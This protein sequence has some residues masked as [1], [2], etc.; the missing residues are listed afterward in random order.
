MQESNSLDYT[1]TVKDLSVLSS[2]QKQEFHAIKSPGSSP[3]RSVS[4]ANDE[5]EHCKKG[6]CDIKIAPK[7]SVQSF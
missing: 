7:I 6:L 3:L 1:T 5:L 4:R 2:A